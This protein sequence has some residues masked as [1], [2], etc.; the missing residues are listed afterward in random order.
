MVGRP[1][2]GWAQ[3]LL[4]ALLANCGGNGGSDNSPTEPGGGL[5]GAADGSPYDAVSPSG[6]TQPIG[7]TPLQLPLVVNSGGLVL[8]SPRIQAIYFPGFPY[9]TEIDRFLANLARGTYWSEVTGEYGVGPLTI[10]PGDAS[11]VM[12]PSSIRDTDVPGLLEEALAQHAAAL[13]PPRPDTIYALFLPPGIDLTTGSMA[14]CGRGPAAYHAEAAVSGVRVPMAV[15]PACSTTPV[16]TSLTG[17]SVLTPALS[18]ELVEAATNP[19][20]DSAPA[21]KSTQPAHVMWAVAMSGGEIADL[22]END[23]PNLITPAELE[24]P[25]IRSWSNRAAMGTSGP[26]APV[27]A[28]ESYFT[29]VAR[30]PT[31]TR[32]QL[33]DG[34]VAEVPSVV[35][36]AGAAASVTVDFRS[37]EASL[38]WRVLALE[39]HGAAS[40]GSL[41][42]ASASAVTGRAGETHSIPIVAPTTASSGIFPLVIL[43]RSDRGALHLWVGAIR[44]Q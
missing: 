40:A 18:H 42:A 29:A 27:P 32:L 9:A 23:R 17:A 4:L 19:L 25:V 8:S 43:S 15:I 39:F 37:D 5:D 6:G 35:A 41:T 22:C 38:S 2:H 24:F 12:V 7:G 21:F 20:P 36:A 34:T 28:G 30:L 16:D 1:E 13:G 31:T 26:C 10:L 33:P 44:R 3:I 14:F 11:A